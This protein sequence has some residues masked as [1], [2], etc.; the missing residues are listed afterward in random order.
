MDGPA[1]DHHFVHVSDGNTLDME[2]ISVPT[3]CHQQ[4]VGEKDIID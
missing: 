2:T 4:K 1:P 3:S